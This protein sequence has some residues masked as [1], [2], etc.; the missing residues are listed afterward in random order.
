MRDLSGSDFLPL[1][2]EFLAQ[3]IGVQRNSVSIVAHTLQQAGLIRYSRGQI[4][5][6]D[7]PGLKETSCECYSTVKAHYDRLLSE[8]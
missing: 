5:I 1:T 4:E 2:Q 3:M 6:L 7:L 8:H